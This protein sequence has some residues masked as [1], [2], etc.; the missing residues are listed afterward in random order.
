LAYGSNYKF[1]DRM[2]QYLR[3]MKYWS[4]ILDNYKIDSFIS[5]G[6]PHEVFDYIIY[7]LCK[8]KGIKSVYFAQTGIPGRVQLLENIESNEGWLFDNSKDVSL[9][10]PLS[11]WAEQL[12]EKMTAKYEPPFFVD[13]FQKRVNKES[14]FLERLKKVVQASWS[15]LLKAKKYLKFTL[16]DYSRWLYFYARVSQGA[17]MRF[18]KFYESISFLPDYSKKYIYVPLHYQPESTTCPQGGVFVFQELMIEMLL[19]SLP[20]G[21]QLYIKENPFQGVVGRNEDFYKKFSNDPNVIWIRKDV[22]SIDLIRNAVTVATVTGTSAWEALF[23]K[24]KVLL[25]GNVYFQYAPGVYRVS[26]LSECKVAIEDILSTGDVADLDAM[27]SFL[28]Q[29]EQNT[30]KGWFIPHW[31]KESGIGYQENLDNLLAALR[32][33]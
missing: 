10:E 20:E 19:A 6:H 29:L 31:G 4:Y 1:D 18:R 16:K 25:F 2:Q 23:Q 27:K 13:I 14:S 15:R 24:K 7:T 22:S 3:H 33:L 11:P 12:I 5:M 32:S 9:Q 26:E 28:M 21:F 8:I 17:E 30:I